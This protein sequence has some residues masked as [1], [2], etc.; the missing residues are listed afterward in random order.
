MTPRPPTTGVAPWD[1]LAADLDPPPAPPP[2]AALRQLVQ[3][4]GA[5]KLRR[6]LRE[7]A[8]LTGSAALIVALHTLINGVRPNLAAMPAPWFTSVA[9]GWAVA[10]VAGLLLPLLPARGSVLPDAARIAWAALVIP[11]GAV[12]LATALN[13][14]D[15]PLSRA[16]PAAQ[17]LV[18]SARCLLSG[19]YV[20][21][22]PWALA[23]AML[24]RAAPLASPA[25]AGAALGA[26]AG[27]LGSLVLHLH[28]PLASPLHV[29]TGHAASVLV[30]AVVGAVALPW[31]VRAPA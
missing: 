4:A 27:A 20:A 28:C 24:R 10:A 22:I 14:D 18:Y 25:W 11:A 16:I 12:L 7:A 13:V 3:T 17:Q 31:F 1:R 19:L 2:S 26:G 5:V 30:A 21:A 9:F 23:S 29:L 8:A 6:P 15:P